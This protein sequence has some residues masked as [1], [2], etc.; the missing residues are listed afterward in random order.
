MSR[1][2]LTNKHKKNCLEKEFWKHP[3]HDQLIVHEILWRWGT[4]YCE[5]DEMPEV[6]LENDDGF[7]VYDSDFETDSLDDGCWEEWSW[8]DSVSEE[9]RQR[10]EELWNEDGYSAWEDA[11]IEL[12]DS[13]IIL[14]GSLELTE[15]KSSQ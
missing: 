15:E 5:S 4:F 7:A 1:W 9:E 14:M 3:D 12:F 8:P 6:D 11:G 13:E 10:L 2:I